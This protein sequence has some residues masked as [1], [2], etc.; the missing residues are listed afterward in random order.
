MGK[1]GDEI[2]LAAQELTAGAQ[3]EFLD[4]ACGSDAALR[5]DVD[6]LLG[7]PASG[8]PDS[9]SRLANL[10][11]GMMLG[12]FRVEERIG[13]GGGGL[14]YR[15]VDTQLRRTVAIKI[16]PESIAADASTRR[17]FAREAEAASALNHPNIVTVYQTGSAG[18]RDYIV[19][20]F[21]AGQTLFTALNRRGLPVPKMLRYAIE[22]ADALA[23]AHRAG[24]VHRDLKT[25]NVMLDDRGH[26]KVLDF[27]LAESSP[28]IHAGS[29]AETITVTAE[30]MVRGTF[31]YMSPEQACGKRVD[32]RSDIFSFGCILYE[33]LTG[34]IVFRRPDPMQTLSAVLQ[35][36]PPPVSTVVSGVP[37]DV[38]RVIDMCLRKDPRERWHSLD[39]VKILLEAALKDI[40]SGIAPASPGPKLRPLWPA[41]AGILCGALLAGAAV[42]RWTGRA[43]LR[44]E[45][46]LTMLTADAGLS[47]FPALS[48]D[49]S[50]FA[51]AS[52]RSGEGNLD[53]WVQQ[54]GGG[55]PIRLTR[56][57]SDES[58]PDVSPDGTRVV[59]RSEKDGGGVYVAP[60]LG[61]EPLLLVAE[62]RNPRFS[63]DGSRIAYWTGRE[64]PGYL[65]DSA[66]V[67]AIPA[68]GGKPERL[69]TGFVAGLYPIWSPRG[70]ALLALAR[71]VAT[72][73]VR[74]SLDWWVLPF[75]GGPKRTGALQLI[76]N[77]KIQVSQGQFYSV[78][79]Q[80]RAGPDRVLFSG[81][82]GDAANVWELDLDKG[83]TATGKS[84][85]IT[86]GSNFET[87]ASV[88][89]PAAGDRPGLLKPD[90]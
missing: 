3:R 89:T 17:R 59:F 42:W 34:Q 60:T 79:L 52:D 72:G 62:G 51:F 25:G 30:H 76:D 86:A 16:L 12:H 23:T 88:A 8:P 7:V 24:I 27:G 28:V 75:Q 58:D 67:Y 39:D 41:A 66:H 32:A 29:D 82:S 5:A 35:F 4:R 53:I 46:P 50:I 9:G 64:G 45:A 78:A 13:E 11:P 80:W 73:R 90:P 84:R 47:A 56:W 33:M 21:I 36:E 63:P 49:G 10:E 48:R 19:M 69:D 20:E 57:D 87:Q 26:V 1:A 18:S 14:V 40:E 43:S 74:D 22:I 77:Q 55:E 61:G 6:R 15:A 38:E 31:A 70:D 54:I 81:N 44:S 83:L 71:K 37:R 65:P 85:R 68:G 2:Y